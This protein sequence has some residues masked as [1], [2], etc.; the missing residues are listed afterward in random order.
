MSHRPAITLLASVALAAASFSTN[1]LAFGHGGGGGFHGGGGGFHGG[2]GG[3][4][5]GFG[6]F[7]GG[8]GFHGVAGHAFAGHALAGHAFA[9]HAVTGHAFARGRAVGNRAL[10][11]HALA[12]HT[13]AG[14]RLATHAPA[15][16]TLGGRGLDERNVSRANALN[17]RT[18]FAAARRFHGLYNFNHAGFNRNAFGGGRAWNRWGGRFWGAGWNQWGWGFGGWAGPVF[19]PFLYGDIFSFAFWPYDYYDPFWAYG[20]DFLLGSVYA[21][22]PGFEPSGPYQANSNIYSGGGSQE[23][24]AERSE[25]AASCG[26]L[27]PGVGGLP[28]AEIRQAIRPT[29]DQVAALDQLNAASI[30]ANDL[31]KQSCPTAI[32]LTPM[33]RLDTAEQRLQT[34]VEAIQVVRPPLEKFYDSLTPEQKQRLEALGKSEHKGSQNG[35]NTSNL[36]ALC[37]KDENF[38]K[39]PTQ[40]I[41]EVVQPNAQ[42]QAAFNELTTTSQTVAEQLQ[43]SCPTEMPQTPVARL[44][45]VNTRLEAMIA[46]MNTI[47]P[48]LAAFYDSLSDDQKARFNT[49]GPPPNASTRAANEHG[50]R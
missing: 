48:K 38:A 22:G 2:G 24:S 31:I 42:Q 7:H 25:A 44:D 15:A 32:P 21:P 35:A 19:W 49:M 1:A 29:A 30:K 5:G 23:T 12:G 18:R 4:H 17:G 26:D 43:S 27:A 14:H 33:A 10:A 28:L 34:M 41:E 36:A 50:N 37:G 39:V 3:F 46:A 20:P 8:G 45:A 11:S 13:F 16:H 47:K 40:R 6:G 9:G